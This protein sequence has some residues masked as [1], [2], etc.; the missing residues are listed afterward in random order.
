MTSTVNI[1][2]SLRVSGN[3]FGLKFQTLGEAAIGNK[4][5]FFNLSKNKWGLP[6]IESNDAFKLPGL[7]LERRTFDLA[8]LGVADSAN[9]AENETQGAESE[10]PTEDQAD[11]NIEVGDNNGHTIIV[12][13]DGNKINVDELEETLPKPYEGEQGN[14][15]GWIDFLKQDEISMVCRDDSGKTQNI[16]GKFETKTFNT[17]P[18]EFT[19]TDNSSGEEHV[20]TY[21]KVGVDEQGRP[22]YKCI[23]MNGNE[24]DDNQYTLVWK[25]DGTPELVQ[26][27]NQDNYGIGLRRKN[28]AA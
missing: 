16:S 1:G 11:V 25:E 28:A 27:S 15:N 13:G 23:S 2:D 17:N 14:V 4:Y 3:R 26:Y 22:L 6:S 19:I 10:N 20:Y 5:D 12:V 18:D 21:K 8:A 24:L 9:E 7:S